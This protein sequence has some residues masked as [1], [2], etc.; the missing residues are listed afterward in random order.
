MI[1]Y[2]QVEK[3][4]FWVSSY[5]W[6][7]SPNNDWGTKLTIPRCKEVIISRLINLE[8]LNWIFQSA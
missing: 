3:I 1:A 6:K 2:I 5:F 7:V 4:K 8:R